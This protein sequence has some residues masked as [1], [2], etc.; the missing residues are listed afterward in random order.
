[1]S[2][3]STIPSSRQFHP[4]Q[5]VSAQPA[6]PRGHALFRHRTRHAPTRLRSPTIRPD[7]SDHSGAPTTGTAAPR[8]VPT[9]HRALRLR[10][11]AG[12]RQAQAGPSAARLTAHRAHLPPRL[13]AT[14]RSHDGCRSAACRPGGPLCYATWQPRSRANAVHR[15]IPPPRSRARHRSRPG[16][17]G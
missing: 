13:A 15:R 5:H 12:P 3:K 16:G 4:P 6:Q 11:P 2:Y 1:M 8:S 9:S 17:D 10:G 7:P 14:I